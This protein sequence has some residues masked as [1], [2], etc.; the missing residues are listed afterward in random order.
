MIRRPPRSTQSRSSA[1][2]D[3]YK[4]QT[5]SGPSLESGG[6]GNI[7]PDVMNTDSSVTG[8]ATGAVRLALRHDMFSSFT[9]LHL[10]GAWNQVSNVPPQLWTQTLDRI[11]DSQ[12]SPVQHIYVSILTKLAYMLVATPNAVILDS[13]RI[14]NSPSSTVDKSY[15][16]S[17]IRTHATS[18]FHATLSDMHRKAGEDAQLSLIHI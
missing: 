9:L 15:I 11:C 5:I 4:R 3:V 7:S 17:V 2:S 14:S 8:S 16:Q 18:L 12:H 1:A 6:V 13:G 10:I